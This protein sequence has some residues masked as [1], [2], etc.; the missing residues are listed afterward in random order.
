[1]NRKFFYTGTA[2]LLASLGSVIA[3]ENCPDANCASK[4][5]G[6]KA[7]TVNNPAEKAAP[8][9]SFEEASKIISYNEGVNLGQRLA[10]AKEMNSDEFIKGM[11]LGVSGK[12]NTLYTQAQIMEA[13]NVMRTEMQKRQ[14]AEA[15]KFAEEQKGLAVKAKKEAFG[16]KEVKTTASGMEYVVMTA[17]EGEN[18]KATDTVS[19]HYTGKLLNGK[20]FDSSVQR[21]TPAEFPLNGVIKGW[22]EGVQLMKPGAKYTFYIPSALAYGPRGAGA[23]IPPNADLI[24]EIE[25][26]KIVK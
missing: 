14:A 26:L 20:V 4:K 11:Q 25:L 10:E 5:H 17:G 24:F 9:I 21:G 6:A 8:S 7:I 3:D 2:F 18:P 22:T 12:Q 16:D 15:A 19:V 23:D 1:M 13:M